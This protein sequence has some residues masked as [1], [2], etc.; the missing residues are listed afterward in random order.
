MKTNHKR[1]IALMDLGSNSSRMTIF[2]IENGVAS[3]V[4]RFR[5]YVRLSEG[6]QATGVL[7]EEPMQRTIASLMGFFEIAKEK[8]AD[9]MILLA[10]EAVRRAENQAEFIASVK[11]ATGLSVT[12]LS[13]KEESYYDYIGS[14]ELVGEKGLL[15]DVGGGSF[16][17]V[18]VCDGK[19]I[20]DT[21]LPEGSVVMADRFSKQEEEMLP[22]FKSA[23]QKMIPTAVIGGSFVGLGGTARAA[24]TLLC[25][26]KAKKNE[27]HGQVVSKADLQT[28]YHHI[29]AL[30][31]AERKSLPIVGAERGDIL[32][33]GLALLVAAAELLDAD[34]ILSSN[35]VREGFL[36]EY[37]KK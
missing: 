12:V 20:F 8:H 13:G 21:C 30:S 6:L 34:M 15:L 26:E 32:L 9:E 31:L 11:E 10:T 16:E 23:F 35:G 5:D 18:C 33:S 27:S 14:K 24:Y 17:M 28:L 36:R 4:K 3:V 37:L 19:M 29:A 22:Y 1:R 25:G 7:S 2:E